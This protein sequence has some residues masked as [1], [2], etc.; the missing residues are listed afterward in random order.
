VR[1][2][3]IA[4]EHRRAVQLALFAFLL[5]VGFLLL[6]SRAGRADAVGLTTPGLPG[7]TAEIPAASPVAADIAAPGVTHVTATLPPASSTIATIG[8]VLRLPP[9]AGLAVEAITDLGTDPNATTPPGPQAAT[10]A[11]VEVAISPSLGARAAGATRAD[12]VRVERDSTDAALAPD[13]FAPAPAPRPAPPAIPATSSLARTD[14]GRPQLAAT[15]AVAVALVILFP[16][17]VARA[18]R[19]V[20]PTLSFRPLTRPG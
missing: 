12:P 13:P 18:R 15:L 6:L 1:G 10:A 4:A 14:G 19:L 7:T 20:L 2:E 11:P 17:G 9:A 16:V 5:G 8:A 3:H